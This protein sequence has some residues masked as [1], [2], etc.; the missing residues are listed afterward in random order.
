MRNV[1]WLLAILA[2]CSPDPA[3]DSPREFSYDEDS[4]QC[5]NSLGEVGFNQ[6]DLVKIRVS[7]DC[8]CMKFSKI[9]VLDVMG[10]TIQIPR[11]FA[12]LKIENY[13]F[14]G[15]VLDSC[16]LYFNNLVAAD[17]RGTDLSTLQ[18]GYALVTG[19]IDD[20]TK[21]PLSGIIE[22]RANGDSVRCFN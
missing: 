6:V 8:E 5:R 12:Y 20:F 19:R 18:Y 15:S 7:K 17:L 13:N 11:R 3:P 14:K 2:A 21:L 10:D 9:Q 4:G 16:N 1:L 22:V